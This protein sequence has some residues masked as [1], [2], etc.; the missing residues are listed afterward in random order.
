MSGSGT[1]PALI[2]RSL[3]PHVK[4]EADSGKEA[5]PAYLGQDNLICNPSE[6]EK[7]ISIPVVASCRGSQWYAA[8]SNTSFQL[9]QRHTDSGSASCGALDSVLL[10]SPDPVISPIRRTCSLAWSA[11]AGA[12]VCTMR[13]AR[14]ACGP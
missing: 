13:I 6:E 14:V 12:T 5:T 9:A 3:G 10:S 11:G 7:K 8:P 1:R 2:V 4:Q